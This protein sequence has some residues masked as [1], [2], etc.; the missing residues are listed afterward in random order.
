MSAAD[1][2]RPD[3]AGIDAI[4]R[5]MIEARTKEALEDA[6]G[7]TQTWHISDSPSLDAKE[8]LVR[9]VRASKGKAFLA[10]AMKAALQLKLLLG[11]RAELLK[12]SRTDVQD[13]VQALTVEELALFFALQQISFAWTYARSTQ[14]VEDLWQ[15]KELCAIKHDVP[16]TYPGFSLL[17]KDMLRPEAPQ[18]K[19]RY[20]GESV[21]VKARGDEHDALFSEMVAAREA[22][23]WTI[24]KGLEARMRLWY[25]IKTEKWWLFA[26]TRLPSRDNKR[27]AEFVSM[28][29]DWVR[30]RYGSSLRAFGA[31][32]CNE[33]EDEWGF[34]LR[35]GRALNEHMTVAMLAQLHE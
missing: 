17:K 35:Q 32:R 26:N 7:D 16:G 28:L 13:L 4:R 18:R 30:D 21:N 23:L 3:R 1:L 11:L 8:E 27:N 9:R 5:T 12:S 33:G 31:W 29:F 15:R 6:T 19:K 34:M 10:D 25:D 14:D 22:G 2:A 20:G 24:A